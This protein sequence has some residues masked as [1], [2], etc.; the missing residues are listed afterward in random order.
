MIEKIVKNVEKQLFFHEDI[1]YLL[2][3]SD[4]SI[5]YL[6][7]KSVEINNNYIKNI[8]LESKLFFPM[9][10]SVES[11][12]PTCGYRTP[13]S[14]KKY[15]PQ[16]IESVI[17]YKISLIK[18]YNINKVNCYNV[19]NY[20]DNE[21][22]LFLKILNEEDIDKNIKI[23]NIND[24]SYVEKYNFNG[25]IVDSYNTQVINAIQNN[26]E[27]LKN[28]E[29][30]INLEIYN[31]KVEENIEF[32]NKSK[33]YKIDSIEIVGY[34]PF[35][36]DVYEYNPQYTKEYLKK[37][38]SIIKIAYPEK[39]LKI[40]YATNNNNYFEDILNIGVNTI[41]GIYCEKT[42]ELFNVE[43]IRKIIHN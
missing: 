13:E 30:I 29:I 21:K 7:E 23:D 26:K 39:E 25:L 37:T 34:D 1:N 12:C 5:N 11:S 41:N 14:H 31:N 32:L 15:N 2:S 43:K 36:D 42:S 40:S 8:N 6:Y 19:A 9:T 27:L 10:Y 3:C 24:L 28:H 20:K 35:Y 38:I 18:S 16:Y 22:N 33:K 4:E 17:K